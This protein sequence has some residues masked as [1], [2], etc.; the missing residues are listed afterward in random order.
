M[1]EGRGVL[2]TGCK[3]FKVSAPLRGNLT[4]EG[5]YILLEIRKPPKPLLGWSFSKGS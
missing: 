5:P 2:H 3:G 4:Q 1:R